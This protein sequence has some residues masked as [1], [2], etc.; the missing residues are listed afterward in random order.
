MLWTDLYIVISKL[1]NFHFGWQNI[2]A[3]IAPPPPC[4]Y[5]LRVLVL[6]DLLV[7]H[8]V[9]IWHDA[10]TY[11]VYRLNRWSGL[12]RQALAETFRLNTPCISCGMMTVTYRKNVWS[13]NNGYHVSYSPGLNKFRTASKEKADAIPCKF[14]S[15]NEWC[16]NKYGCI[17]TDLDIRVANISIISL[18]FCISL[19]TQNCYLFDDRNYIFPSN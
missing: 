4:S 17:M 2:G 9:Q 7:Q 19:W 15:K 6:A 1:F 11:H 18:Q 12:A 5:D 13:K 3:A 16:F 10:S 8:V 14:F